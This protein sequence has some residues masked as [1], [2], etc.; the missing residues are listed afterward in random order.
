MKAGS[1]IGKADSCTDFHQETKVRQQGFQESFFSHDLASE[2]P[3]PSVLGLLQWCRHQ[4]W[5]LPYDHP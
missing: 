1:L 2:I 4:Q 3:I 5:S